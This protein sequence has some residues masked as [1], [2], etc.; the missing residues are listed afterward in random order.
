[1]H[2]IKMMKKRITTNVDQ[3]LWKQAQ[4][5]EISWADALETGIKVLTGINNDKEKLL[6]K[7]QQTKNKLDVY[8]EKL[9]QI[10]E[11]EAKD[12]ADRKKEVV[13]EWE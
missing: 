3:N 9:K 1:M 4:I 12:K 2:T 5:A 7:I 11:N 6:V 8:N 10:E 13:A